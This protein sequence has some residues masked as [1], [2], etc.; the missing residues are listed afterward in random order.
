MMKKLLLA[1]V[2][3]FP[4]LAANAQSDDA[5][6]MKVDNRPIT[7][8]EFKY[9]YEKNNG[10]EATYTEKSIREYL[11]LYSRFKLKVARARDLKLDTIQSLND[12]LNGYKRQL[13]NSYLTDREIMDHLLKQLQE[14]QKE[15][16]QFSHILVSAPEKSTDSVKVAAL[17]KAE[18]IKKE[19]DMGKS[20]EAAAK[21]YSDDKGTGI[22]GGDL[23]FFTAMLPEGF[24]DVENAL[25]TLPN[26]KVSAPIKSKI[27]YHLIKVVG[28]RPARGTISVAHIL[29]K[30]NNKSEEPKTKIEE[31]YNQLLGGA[32][33]A[34]VAAQY[35]EDKQT[36]QNGG[37]LP[38]FGINTYDTAFEDAAFALQNDGD[39]SKPIQTKTGW[40]IIKRIKK[41]DADMDYAAFKKM[42][43]PRIKKDER[44]TIAKKRLVADIKNASGFKE[45]EDVF[46]RFTAGLNEEFLSF[47]WTPD[48]TTEIMKENLMSFG[49]DTQYTVG[50]FASFCKKNTK[51]RLKYDKNA[52]AVKE[53][54]RALLLEFSEEKAI[55]YEQKL[56]EVKYPDFKALMRE[57]EEGILLFEAT[58]RAVWD[59]ANQDSTGLAAYHQKYQDN[60]KTEEKAAL[61]TYTV[62]T[63]E[64]D[65]A[66]KVAKFAA[67]KNADEV[68]KKFNKKTQMVSYVEETLE[69]QNPK[70]ASMTWQKDFQTTVTKSEDGQ[71][72]V[73]SKIS[74]I[75]PV[76]NKTLKEARVRS[77]SL[78]K[79][80]WWRY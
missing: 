5:V 11:E 70:F 41:M 56:L 72:F 47:K 67:K 79:V 16:V 60:Y 6:L 44:F 10:K 26:G 75:F 31:A 37:Y 62:K 52:T 29:I 42:Y 22:N 34:K 77:N 73:F 59:R 20:F 68:M 64:M 13:A 15:D 32:D 27:G 51:S 46:N 28:K 65:E 24:Y 8:G 57:Y 39:I 71:G 30:N 74:Q 40:H 3:G 58:K 18:K 9:I 49:G 53:V 19:I 50:E 2:F 36:A 1:L 12:E 43:E 48:L 17:A 23:G 25:Y 14:R 80:A 54:A 66:E 45:N 7:V 63:T 69:K 78:Q 55:D 38:T 61:L 33:F 76:R 21:E 35:S 4:V